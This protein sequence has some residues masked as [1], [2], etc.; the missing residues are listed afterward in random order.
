MDEILDRIAAL[1]AQIAGLPAG[2][3]TKKTVSGK[4]YFYHRWTEDK[5]RR[6]KYI[7]EEEV[8]ALREQIDQRKALETELKALKKQAPKKPAPK[9]EKFIMNV[10]IGD[11]LRIYSAP[12]RRYKKRGCYQTLHDFVYGDVQDR[13]FILCG[14]RRT[15]INLSPLAYRQS[16]QSTDTY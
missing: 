13:V 4:I 14:L 7:P 12:V 16:S 2:S 3:I 5:K 10:R 15:G 8:P 9:K 1:E 11:D 6:E